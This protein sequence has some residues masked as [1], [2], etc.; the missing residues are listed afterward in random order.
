MKKTGFLMTIAAL[1]IA[2]MMFGCS[3]AP[4]QELSAA[5][6]ILDSA[7][8]MEADKYMAADFSAA[9]DSLNAAMVEIEKQKSANLLARN[10]DRAKSLIL[11]ASTAARHAQIQAPEEKR[12]V[13][14]AVDTL[15]AQASS[16]VGEANALLAKAPKGKEGKAAL[17]AIGNDISTVKASLADAQA[18]SDKGDLVSARDKANAGISKLDSI[19]AEL[20]TAIEKTSSKSKS[21]SKKK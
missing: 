1:S 8:V 4:Q 19:K 11:S 3:K 16:M 14:A 13:K 15:L 2:G 7:A 6:A 5:K 20:T 10:Y 21:K 18:L 17:E 12:K 9:Q